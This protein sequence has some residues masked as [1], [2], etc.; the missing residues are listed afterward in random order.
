MSG[1]HGTS[2]RNSAT[3]V[4]DLN[5]PVLEMNLNLTGSGRA[6]KFPSARDRSV[7]V[8]VKTIQSSCAGTLNEPAAVDRGHVICS[9][10]HTQ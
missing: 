4:R 10:G 6:R 9:S 3:D 5:S 8:A 2:R 1:V 7:L